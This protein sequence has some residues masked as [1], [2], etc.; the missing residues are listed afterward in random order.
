MKKLLIPA[1][2][3]VLGAVALG[4]VG[5][6]S[7]SVKIG[8]INSQ[9]IVSSS[10]AGKAAAAELT[11]FIKQRNDAVQIMR[12]ELVKMTGELEQMRK[13]KAK[14]LKEREAAFEQKKQELAQ[15]LNTSRQEIQV[16]ERELAEKIL[17][18]ALEIIQDIGKDQGYTMIIEVTSGK[19]VYDADDLDVSDEVIAK[20]D[21]KLK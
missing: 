19:L 20:L 18:M 13:A 14:E 6:L 9:Q 17:P 15:V 4:L 3:F 11:G 16:K 5:F 12:D 8:F 2:L 21:A 1:I 7:S 10:E